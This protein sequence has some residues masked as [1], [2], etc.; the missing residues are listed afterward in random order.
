MGSLPLAITLSQ[1][2][3][4]QSM[5]TFS[6]SLLA[7]S[8]GDSLHHPVGKEEDTFS[9]LYSTRNAAPAPYYLRVSIY[10]TEQT[11]GGRRRKR[12][13]EEGGGREGEEG[14]NMGELLPS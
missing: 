1:P 7:S 8:V 12:K 5:I 6:L 10:A 2:I 3:L 14:G 9:C 11:C 4:L 13:E